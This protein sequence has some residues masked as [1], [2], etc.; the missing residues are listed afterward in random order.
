MW[1]CSSYMKE[2]Y[3]GFY[4]FFSRHVKKLLS[5]SLPHRLDPKS[6]DTFGETMLGE[7]IDE[8]RQIFSAHPRVDVKRERLVGYGTKNLKEVIFFFISAHAHL[9]FVSPQTC[10][11][12]HEKSMRFF[13]SLFFFAKVWYI[14]FCGAVRTGSGAR[15]PSLPLDERKVKRHSSKN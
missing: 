11:I 10:G 1:V 6:L 12:Y 13:C 7:T 4:C 3:I 14:F 8:N 2:K 9:L 15:G 5:P